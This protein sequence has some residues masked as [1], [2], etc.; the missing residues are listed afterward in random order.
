M[1]VK[2]GQFAGFEGFVIRRA[3]QTCL[4]VEVRFM[5][6]GSFGS[7]GRLPTRGYRTSACLITQQKISY[8][9]LQHP[10]LFL[11]HHTLTSKD[12]ID[13]WYHRPKMGSYLTEL[14]LRKGYEV[15]GLV[16]RSSNTARL[17]LDHLTIDRDLYNQ[18]LFL[19]Y[20]DLEDT[21]TLRRLMT[22]LAPDEIYHLAGQSHVGLSFEI[23]ESTCEFTA[24]ENA[25]VVR[26]RT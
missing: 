15:H 16:R 25:K 22:K 11:G 5:N 14:L 18:Q 12:C 20:A 7:V 19:H 24:M 1:R 26:N 10:S 2:S 21:T 8:G 6:Q 4:I 13:H 17:R 23:P 9:A 3:Q